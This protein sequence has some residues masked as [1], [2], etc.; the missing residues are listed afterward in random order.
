MNSG[1]NRKNGGRREEKD[2]LLIHKLIIHGDEKF[3][4]IGSKSEKSLDFLFDQREG[5]HACTHTARNSRRRSGSKPSRVRGR[6]ASCA[7]TEMKYWT[8]TPLSLS[9][10]VALCPCLCLS[11]CLSLSL[12]TPLYPSLSHPLC[13]SLSIYLPSL[14]PPLPLPLP[15]RTHNALLKQSL[16]IVCRFVSA[17]RCCACLCPCI[18]AVRCYGCDTPACD[19][20]GPT[21]VP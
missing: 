14:S 17:C 4:V 7:G 21:R 2:E 9:L 16:F 10:S 1:I 15:L 5:A 19:A 11:L 18:A 13:L 8:H 3:T 12:S 20:D 6:A